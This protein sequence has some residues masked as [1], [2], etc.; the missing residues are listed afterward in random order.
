MT[1]DWREKAQ[2]M[3]DLQDLAYQ[4]TPVGTWAERWLP[5]VCK[6][7]AV[8]CTHGD[9]IIARRFRRRVCMIC[10]RSLKGPLP[11]VCFFSPTGAR[12]GA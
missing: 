7:K 10:G 11:E 6:H 12:H 5:G 3:I 4:R 2:Q 1:D 8:R 9:E